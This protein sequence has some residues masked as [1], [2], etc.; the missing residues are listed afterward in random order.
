MRALAKA[1]ALM[2]NRQEVSD[3]DISVLASWQGYFTGK[4]PIEI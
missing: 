1:L 3:K 2:D 4:R